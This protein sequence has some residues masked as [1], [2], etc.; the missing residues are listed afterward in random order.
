MGLNVLVFCLTFLAVLR[1]ST[2][3][4]PSFRIIAPE[5]I[6]HPER[7]RGNSVSNTTD[8]IQ[9]N[10]S[11]PVANPRQLTIGFQTK[12]GQRLHYRVTT[13]FKLL[14]GFVSQRHTLGLW[15]AVRLLE[16]RIRRDRD[17]IAD[18]GQLAMNTDELVPGAV[19]VFGV[20]GV[21]DD[22][23][24]SDEQNFT[25]TYRSQEQGASFESF[26]GAAS[27]NDDVSLLLLGS[28]TAYADMEYSVTAQLIFCRRRTD[29]FFRWSIEGLDEP[30]V[31]VS[32]ERSETLR[33]P[34]DSFTPG[35]TYG[36]HVEVHTSSGEQGILTMT[37]MKVTILQRQTT[38][39]LVPSE[40]V[41]GIN[42][43]TQIKAHITGGR[44]DLETKW[45]CLRE[46]GDTKECE[47]MME[48]GDAATTATFFKVGNY[49]ITAS[50]SGIGTDVASNTLLSVNSKVLPSVRL[51]EWSQYP[52]VSG[53]PFRM[54]VSVSGLVPKC[55]SNWTVLREDGFAYFD[56]S[57]IP[58]EA[59]VEKGSL[60]NFYIRDIEENFLSE[61]VDYGNDTVVKDIVLS[62][63]GADTGV[64][65]SWKGLEP[66]VRYK[67][68]LETKCPEPI[69][70]D[71][72]ITA[73][74]ERKLVESHW[75]FVLETNGAPQAPAVEVTPVGNGTALETVFQII[76]GLAKDSKQDYPL[77]Y[78][79][80]YVADGVDINVG[81]FYEI[82]SAETVL[83]YTRNGTVRTYVV[84]CD[85]R[86]ACTKADGPEVHIVLGKE[87]SD[88]EIS[89]ALGSIDGFFDRLN[90][91]EALKVA[92]E[93]LVTLRNQNSPRYAGT[94]QRF[95]DIFRQAVVRVGKMYT[96]TTFLS[97]ATIQQFIMQAKPILDLEEASNHELFQQLLELM[98]PPGVAES[99]PRRRKRSTAPVQASASVAKISNKL[100]LMEGMT[101]SS[102][103]S[104]ARESRT[105][106]LNY[107]HQAAKEYCMSVSYH[108]YVGQ[109]I[110]L[111][112]NRHRSLSEV[113][114]QQFEITNKVLLRVPP[115]R[116]EFRDAFPETEYFCVG[117]VYYARDIFVERA[118]H[119][120]D[121]G[122]YETFLL[123]IEKGG[124]WTLIS[125]RSDYFLWSLDGRQLPNVT[126]QL[127]ED[128]VWTGKHCITTE[129]PTDEVLCNCTKMGYLRLSN[130]TEPE[131]DTSWSTTDM[132]STEAVTTAE[133][134]PESTAASRMESTSNSAVIETSSTPAITTNLVRTSTPGVASTTESDMVTLPSR[135]DA[136]TT[137]QSVTEHV[138]LEP[139]STNGTS[140]T[141]HGPSPLQA[142]D[143]SG[144]GKALAPTGEPL[145]N[146]PMATSSIAYTILGALGISTLLMAVLTVAYRR[147]RVVLRLADELHT[148]PNRARTQ[149]PHVR[150]ARFQDEHNMT[151]DNVSTI[152]DVLTI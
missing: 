90:L 49:S 130:E 44:P 65:R 28:E 58:A 46:E 91:R 123:S 70:Y 113:N 1:L 64:D 23:T 149:S 40:A 134:V 9:R 17:L 73:Q 83:P 56:P 24:V 33:V 54:L 92:F 77:R 21:T 121:L 139:P 95:V 106:L 75:T 60:G 120:L 76:S 51:L 111:T 15:R 135:A 38:L 128:D 137:P 99:V 140:L 96:E 78:S 85:S 69:D 34:A 47:D 71:Q 39:V 124:M 147:R 41:V 61:L 10:S 112:V 136:S 7:S 151:G 31:H 27:S 97:E 72:S 126:C 122:F 48:I 141:E 129:T 32:M 119:E 12:G 29:Y 131:L 94:Y 118:V 103:V 25:M 63:P 109:L 43:P 11:E 86:E 6:C 144:S 67:F 45:T 152:S 100:Y 101:A 14:D 116:S 35:H 74:Q 20:V 13:Y 98:E 127:R 30:S 145:H 37:R 19:Y 26:D 79:F 138:T 84:V 114:F 104:V 132:F 110:T 68:R 42:Q 18:S 117:R 8:S 62:I 5:F 150:Y 89:F 148:V 80:W 50:T 3:E 57:E 93:L 82:T 125:W 115:R 107:V 88:E 59:D 22:G 55:Q 4:N 102:N 142:G 87:P 66:D 52:A 146:R 2:A 108:E 133:T 16:Q 143:I 53:A 36:I 81:S 105:A